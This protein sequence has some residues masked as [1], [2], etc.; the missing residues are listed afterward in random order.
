MKVGIY[1]DLRNPPHSQMDT[2]RLYRFTLELCE[3]AERLGIDSVWVSEHHLFADG[4]LPQPLT[5]LAMV[6]A[7]TSRVRLGTAVVIA[8]LHSTID[9]AESAA[10]VDIASGGRLELGLGAGY[11]IPE[12]SLYGKDFSRRYAQTDAAVADIQRIWDEHAVTPQPVQE[13]VPIWL[14]YQGPQGARR[15][16]RLGVGLLALRGE[17]L[18]PYRTGLHEGGHD[19]AAARMSGSFSA[20]ATDDPE[21]DWP[22]VS[23]HIAYQQDSYRSY[24]VE[25]TSRRAPRPVDPGALTERDVSTLGYFW[26]GTPQEIAARIRAAVAGLPVETVYLWGSIGGMDEQLSLRCVNTICTAVAPLLRAG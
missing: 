5:F 26:F 2:T 9:L 21:R 12:Y 16:G 7:R 18:V 22:V 3:E 20:Y 4:Y 1:F 13:P 6:A 8:P 24:L 11:R 19:V 17:L 10:L 15:A 14:G 23:R 25:G